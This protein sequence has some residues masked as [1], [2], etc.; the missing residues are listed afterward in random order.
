M[1]GQG[2][3]LI[4][5]PLYLIPWLVGL[6]VSRVTYVDDRNPRVSLYC[7]L[8][9]SLAREVGNLSL[10]ARA[11]SEMYGDLAF[12]C[13][14]MAA[15]SA[16]NILVRQTLPSRDLILLF[17]MFVATELL[18]CTPLL[19][20]LQWQMVGACFFLFQLARGLDLSTRAWR[21]LQV[22]LGNR[23]TKPEPD[24]VMQDWLLLQIR[25]AS[26][27]I[28]FICVAVVGLGHVI[29]LTHAPPSSLMFGVDPRKPDYIM[30]FFV[31]LAGWIVA[32]IASCYAINPTLKQ[33]PSIPFLSILTVTKHLSA[34]TTGLAPYNS[35]RM[36]TLAS[37][38]DDDRASQRSSNRVKFAQEVDIKQAVSRLCRDNYRW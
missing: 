9:F 32:T 8:M 7:F 6:C 27:V 26:S 15:A 30:S 14:A 36:T 1:M 37:G 12:V 22:T 33:V 20:G 17:P 34:T 18:V 13:Y 38:N 10:A 16:L 23:S 28:S 4:S 2:S 5:Y 29:Q 3:V 24:E 35:V 21:M 19:C 31:A 25:I 11:Y